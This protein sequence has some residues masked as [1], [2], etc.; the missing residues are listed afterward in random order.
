MTNAKSI[1]QRSLVWS[2]SMSEYLIT[3]L[4]ELL[5][6]DKFVSLGRICCEHVCVPDHCLM[7]LV[8]I[9]NGLNVESD[10]LKGESGEWLS[11]NDLKAVFSFSIIIT[12]VGVKKI[13]I[14]KDRA[15]GAYIR[16]VVYVIRDLILFS[17][18]GIQ[19][20]SEAFVDC[21]SYGATFR[22][23]DDI[24][25]RSSGMDDTSTRN[26]IR[27]VAA[28][29]MK[30]GYLHAENY[31]FARR[32]VSLS[33]ANTGLHLNVRVLKTLFSC[34]IA[35]TDVVVCTFQS[36]LVKEVL[37]SIVKRD[38]LQNVYLFDL[39]ECVMLHLVPSKTSTSGIFERYDQGKLKW[40]CSTVIRFCDTSPENNHDKLERYQT[41]MLIDSLCENN[42]RDADDRN[43]GITDDG[44]GGNSE[45]K[46]QQ[47]VL[48]IEIR[49]LPLILSEKEQISLF[50]TTGTIC[51]EAGF[52]SFPDLYATSMSRGLATLRDRYVLFETFQV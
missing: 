1:D 6:L 8:S 22:Q 9:N 42:S 40:N 32:L 33:Y 2:F 38:K 10:I 3:Q 5:R 4:T 50:E 41:E 52:V 16:R 39:S 11:S 13:I 30:N 21:L 46:T 47:S 19:N 29:V 24:H 31:S 45:S 17:R 7:Q 23:M 27:N 14:Q 15:V 36:E 49:H 25:E 20:L 12:H 37:M 34:A 43:D 18:S 26:A 28:M 51:R 44:S 35:T 48:Y